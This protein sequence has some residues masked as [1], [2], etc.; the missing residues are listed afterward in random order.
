MY[1]IVFNQG[2]GS[3]VNRHKNFGSKRNGTLPRLPI[4]P[5]FL[6]QSP[7]PPQ[8]RDSRLSSYKNN[9]VQSTKN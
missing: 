9:S 4:N 1:S 5:Q 7:P 6:M 2:A 8:L 3:P